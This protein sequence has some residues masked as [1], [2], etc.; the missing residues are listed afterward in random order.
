MAEEAECR[1]RDYSWSDCHVLL[2]SILMSILISFSRD[3]AW[4]LS[5]PEHL[6]VFFDSAILRPDF[7]SYFGN[8]YGGEHRNGLFWAYT[9]QI[10]LWLFDKTFVFLQEFR[11]NAKSHLYNTCLFHKKLRKI[12]ALLFALKTFVHN[13]RSC[14]V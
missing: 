2:C 1:L 4:Y 6:M 11:K 8:C 9:G 3:T 12:S 14:F 5:L 10:L 13:S 7:L